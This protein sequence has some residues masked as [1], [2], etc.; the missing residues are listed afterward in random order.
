MKRQG[1]I[2]LST[3]RHAT[4]W[5]LLLTT[6]V[7]CLPALAGQPIIGSGYLTSYAVDAAGTIYAWGAS[8]IGAAGFTNL[9]V[10]M[11]GPTGI[12]A[13]SGGESYG[14]AL[15]SAGRVFT[16]GS[17]RFGQLGDSSILISSSTPHMI[18]SLS[19]I[20]AVSAGF[21]HAI[22][23]RSDGTVWAWGSNDFG[24]IGDGTTTLHKTPVQVNGLPAI[25]KIATGGRADHSFAIDGSGTLWAWGKNDR[26]QLGDNSTI[27]RFVPATVQALANVVDVGCGQRHS[28][29]VRQDGSIWSWGYNGSSQLGD[30]T[31]IQRLAPVSVY[32]STTQAFRNG[33][34]VSVGA[35][36]TFVTKVDGSVW[37]WGS[38][39]YGEMGDG[40]GNIWPYTPDYAT[41]SPQ[42]K[43]MKVVNGSN[44]SLGMMPDGR[45]W[46]WGRNFS[47]EIGDG[48]NFQ[49][50][51]PVQVRTPSNIGY[52]SLLS[53]NA[54]YSLT[55]DVQGSAGSIRD[56]GN[57]INCIGMCSSF[58]PVGTP[59]SLSAVPNYGYQFSGWSG[60]CTGT[61]IC[62]LAMTTSHSVTASFSAAPMQVYASKSG[63][64]TGVVSSAAS[65]INCGATCS[66]QVIYDT[67]L[68]FTATPTP[69]SVFAGWSVNGVDSACLSNTCSFRIVNPTTVNARF[70]LIPTVPGQPIIV[71]AV[72]GD[73][74]AAIRFLPPQSGGSTP[75]TSFRAICQPGG[76]LSFGTGS[77]IFV[78]SLTNDTPYSCSVAAINSI[79]TSAES[80]TAFVTPNAAAPLSL[81]A[82]H[83]RKQH[84]TAGTFGLPIYFGASNTGAVSVEPRID[85]GSGHTIVFQ[86]N[87]PITSIAAINGTD[88]NNSPVSTAST[89]TNSN[90]VVVGLMS[91][92]NGS[93]VSL[94]LVGPNGAGT[95]SAK[96]GFLIGDVNRTGHV[97]AND[98]TEIKARAGQTVNSRNSSYDVD[99]SGT[100][101]AA[102]IV[103]AR[104]RLLK[105]LN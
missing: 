23:L 94:D 24:Q 49:R 53:S 35:D 10:V 64:G 100:I 104:N 12:V 45:V 19:N 92:A 71:D 44:Y 73:G 4:I 90:E 76:Q 67:N 69:Q 14:L 85:G 9:P 62:K 51:I 58:I 96:V 43:G 103:A 80:A 37:G 34:A 86:F 54:S 66:A 16:W 46:S 57:A 3:W 84:G 26:G 65:G 2:T 68:T 56:N 55:L 48:T 91:I 77:P 41:E 87:N 36:F 7:A 17:N 40:I 81:I 15:T 28:V 102:D 105:S 50:D 42:L 11:S 27:Q 31:T 75:I 21:R 79:G 98:V 32:E 38:S 13:I 8:P 61:A 6:I 20:V 39:V 99:L 33:A 5:Q 63:Y 88:Q 72:A 25:S 60:D 97:D 93:T 74:R 30:R 70:D 83:S 18:P 1:F 89:P 59:V 29:A 22:A 82:V 95:Y 52:L 78:S 101:T 47:G